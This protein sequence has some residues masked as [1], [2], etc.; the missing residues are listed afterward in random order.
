MFEVWVTLCERLFSM[1]NHEAEELFLIVTDGEKLCLWVVS[2]QLRKIT[3]KK[4]KKI[5]FRAQNIPSKF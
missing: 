4:K 1:M 3:W 5:F 2:L